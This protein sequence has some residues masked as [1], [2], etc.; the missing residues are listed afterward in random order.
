MSEF[1]A[2]NGRRVVVYP[3]GVVD[4]ISST[5]ATALAEVEV[6]ALREFF[7]HERNTEL[8]RWRWAENPD[9]VVYPY[10][11]DPPR[12]NVRGVTVV[13]ERIPRVYTV[14]EDRI[15]LPLHGTSVDEGARSAA[16]SAARAY[17]EA[18]PAPK[19]WESAK[20][21][22]LWALTV[23]TETVDALCIDTEFGPDFVS[24]GHRFT[25]RY[26]GIT[27]GRRIWPEVSDA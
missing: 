17:F 2:S 22:E 19:P 11:I 27:A 16:Y 24:S 12:G 25:T 23:D 5:R 18:H 1:T 4:V 7:L 9:Y 3:Y 20:P 21:G 6:E 8:G 13:S 10:P 15:G 14:W 26:V